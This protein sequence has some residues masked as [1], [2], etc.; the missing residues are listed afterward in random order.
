MDVG[1]GAGKSHVIREY[2]EKV[3]NA[4]NPDSEPRNLLTYLEG[5][6]GEGLSVLFVSIRI[7]LTTDW[8]RLLNDKGLG[9]TDYREKNYKG[10]QADR[11]CR[12]DS[13]WRIEERFDIVVIDE[14]QTATKQ[15][16]DH[17]IKAHLSLKKCAN[18]VKK[19]TC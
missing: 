8:L 4:L 7:A 13:L 12:L 11:L 2:L 19:Q 3:N 9:F 10:A 1:M 6:K 17:S 18:I 16:A 15:F 5:A 14:I